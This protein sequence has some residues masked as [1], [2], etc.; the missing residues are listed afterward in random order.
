M[1]RCFVA[2]ECN[3][4]QVVSGFRVV[5]RILEASG[6]HLKNVELENIHLTLKFL[7]EIS[8]NKVEE[9]SRVIEKISFEPFWFKVEG[10]GVFPNLRRPSVVW[11]GVTDGASK[12][13]I[14]Y[15]EL[16]EKLYNLGFKREKRV[17]HPHFTISR[18]RSGRNRN[19]LVEEILKI[20][21]YTFGQIYIDKI[22]LKKSLLTPTGPIYTT[23]AESQH[24]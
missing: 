15:D 18:V 16:E 4:A 12:L 22:L 10:V 2:V 3:E 11:A 23:L 5:Q 9:V 1:V 24:N 13:S 7:G 21:D 20:E 19:Q 6:A 14:I 8:Q 17:F